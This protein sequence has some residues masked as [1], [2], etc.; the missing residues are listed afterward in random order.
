MARIYADRTQE[1]AST[2]GLSDFTLAG[3]VSGYRSF[4]QVMSIGDTCAYLAISGSQ[5][6]V[7]V[8]TKGLGTLART[9]V[10]SSS[11]SNSKVSFTAAPNVLITWSGADAAAASA[12][13][14]GSGTVTSITVTQPAAGLTVTNSGVPATTT[15][16]FTFA[17]T[18]DLAAL[19]A[20]TGT[21]TLYYRSGVSTWT[22]VTIGGNM[23]FSG[24]TLDSVA[25]GTG[26]VTSVSVTTDNGVSGSVATATTTPAITITLGNISPTS[27]TSTFTG[28]L[29]GN[30][31]GNCSGSSG[32]C[33]GNAATASAVALGGITGLGIG[34]AT[35][36]AINIGSA[37][38]PVV[39]N[40]AAG[41]PSSLTLTNATGLPVAGGGTGASTA[42]AANVNLTVATQAI[43]ASDIDWS[44]GGVFSKSISGNTTFT[45]SN[46]Q[47][48]ATKIV[49]VSSSGSYT[50]TWPTVLWVGGTPPVQTLS[51]RDIYTFVRVGSDIIGTV[52]QDV[53]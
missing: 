39:L 17:L 10:Q 41:T 27:V 6:E 3:A 9:T 38:A 52:V 11:N 12:G 16:S 20:L 46:T 50:V 5:W 51:G 21:D 19:E 2:S 8:G 15:G 40:G 4:S 23:T 31:T 24:G 42:A 30:V 25:G 29:T 28:G 13:G 35:T 43:G 14:G 32:S 48:G 36:L 7:G 1:T 53:S 34:V 44:T 45:F 18:D 26:T 22:P 33:T 49:S 37:G 47:D